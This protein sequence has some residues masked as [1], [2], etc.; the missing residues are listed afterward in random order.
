MLYHEPSKDVLKSP[1][2]RSFTSC[3]PFSSMGR[4]HK[5]HFVENRERDLLDRCIRGI[6][7]IMYD[8]I[9]NRVEFRSICFYKTYP[10]RGLPSLTKMASIPLLSRFK[11]KD[12]YALRMLVCSMTSSVPST[13][14]FNDSNI[15]LSSG[16][17]SSSRNVRIRGY[18]VRTVEW[19]EVP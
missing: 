6:C 8:A 2:Q 3:L 1:I 13:G 18:L 7:S 12:R 17:I 11:M 16:I 9:E 19:Q 14:L 4:P 15:R 5:C 10:H